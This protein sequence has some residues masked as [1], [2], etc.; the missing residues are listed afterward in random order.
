[1]PVVPAEATFTFSDGTANCVFVQGIT[2]FTRL[3][4]KFGGDKLVASI[5]KCLFGVER[6]GG[7]WRVAQVD[8]LGDNAT[9]AL[10][11]SRTGYD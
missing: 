10:Q 8:F 3:G 2:Y 4:G 5:R 11:D 7:D 1:M 9:L 6:H